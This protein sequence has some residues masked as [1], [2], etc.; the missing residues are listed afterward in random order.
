MLKV[1]MLSR[2]E[3]LS[4]LGKCEHLGVG[5][6]G[7]MVVSQLVFTLPD[8]TS[9]ETVSGLC[10]D[11]L[12]T[13]RMN[14]QIYGREFPLLSIPGRVTATV[15]APDEDSLSPDYHNHYVQKSLQAIASAGIAV[16]MSS[17]VSELDGMACCSCQHRSA[18]VLFTS[19]AALDSP[20]RCGDCFTP[21]PLYKIPPTYDEQEYY[22]I[23]CWAADYANCDSLQMGC[24]TLERAATQQLS[25]LNS[26][27]SVA[28][29]TAC[30]KI[31]ELT[32]KPTYYY[33]YKH[34]ARSLAK[35]KQRKCPNCGGDWLLEE[36]WHDR[37]DF[38]CDTCLL[39]S[40][41][42]WSVR[43]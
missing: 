2:L 36:P 37:F 20:L 4:T 11:L 28:G 1:F 3:K 5:E 38:R 12:A 8:G 23:I 42:A 29:R 39:L 24:G 16:A 26:S 6:E 35:E 40:N 21:V 41:I 33:L 25:A 13:L 10:N 30:N 18:F 27:L 15:M 43:T 9:P 7:Y 14:G 31:R 19:Y 17:L 22:D 34:N 32:G